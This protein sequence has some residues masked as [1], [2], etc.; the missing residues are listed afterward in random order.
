MGVRGRLNEPSVPSI[1]GRVGR[2]VGG[3]WDTRQ[4]PTATHIR[5]LEIAQTD[6]ADF[7]RELSAALETD[8]PQLEADLEAAGAPWTTGR[9]LSGR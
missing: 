3:H 4:T 8:L 1:R 7:R 5:N 9:R 2:V 6:F